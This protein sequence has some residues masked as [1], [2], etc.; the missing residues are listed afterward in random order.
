MPETITISAFNWVPDF[1]RGNVRDL[2]VRWALEE[3]GWNYA[4]ELLDARN[5]RGEDYVALQPFDQVPIL[6]DGDV[7]LFEAA[8]ILLYLAEKSGK[9]LPADPA[10]KARATSW[11]F[12]SVN[13]VEPPLR[14]VSTFP[15]F[16]ADSDW[17]APAAQALT[18]FAEK[19]LA[20]LSAAL[21][22]KPWIAGEFSV[23]DIM[24]TFILRTL[25]GKPLEGFPGLCA[26]VDRGKARPA[27]Q[28]AY[29]AQLADFTLEDELS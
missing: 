10:G 7:V 20:R 18:P 14:N 17:A 22:D 28:R 24:L 9:L 6:R 3:L 26:Y 21:G 29:D 1:A 5:P 19:R 11:L 2:P 23:A 16:Y 25:G 13:S 4:V 27:Y 12:A 15:L 8:A